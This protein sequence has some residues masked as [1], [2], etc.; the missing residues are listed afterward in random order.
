MMSDG[1]PLWVITDHC[2]KHLRIGHDYS[3]EHWRT[4]APGA[5][6]DVVKK[7][8]LVAVTIVVA[9]AAAVV[10]VAAVHG[11]CW[12]HRHRRARGGRNNDA[13]W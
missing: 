6:V 1:H 13:D 8:G 9:A 4:A 10:V 7:S 3:G 5:Y 12:D 2:C 11:Y